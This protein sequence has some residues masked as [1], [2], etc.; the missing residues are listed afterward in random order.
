MTFRFWSNQENPAAEE[1]SRMLPFDVRYAMQYRE[2]KLG[3]SEILDLA[4]NRLEHEGLYVLLKAASTSLDKQAALLNA[5]VQ[6]VINTEE[7]NS[8]DEVLQT[9]IKQ[10]ISELPTDAAADSMKL[11][12]YSR[13]GFELWRSKFLE[14]ARL[15]AGRKNPTYLVG[16]SMFMGLTE[17]ITEHAKVKKPLHVLMPHLIE[18]SD[19]SFC[20]YVI[21]DNDTLLLGKDFIRENG[22]IIIDDVRNTGETEETVR[23]FWNQQATDTDPEFEYVSTNT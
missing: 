9:F 2:A 4:N 20:G 6:T 7:N 12:Q 23:M 10:H 16:H 1:T 19:N 5:L 11:A 13:Q 18:D 3:P 14:A 15:A 21:I 17:F 8:I 22:A